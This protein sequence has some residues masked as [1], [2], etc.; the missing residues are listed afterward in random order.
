MLRMSFKWI[1]ACMDTSDHGLSLP[2]KVWHS[3][4]WFDNHQK[5]AGE[6]TI[7][8]WQLNWAGVLHVN[9]LVFTLK[10]VYR[11]IVIMNKCACYCVMN[12]SE[13]FP[14][15]FWYTLCLKEVCESFVTFL[16]YL[17]CYVWCMRIVILM[18]SC[19]YKPHNIDISVTFYFVL[20]EL[21]FWAIIPEI[22]FHNSVTL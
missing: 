16:L 13:V 1:N 17:F 6:V 5:Y 15:V 8:S 11:H 9:T 18:N 19:T 3:C 4:E 12:P 22:L 14:S 20:P 2:F 7:F 21:F 10:I